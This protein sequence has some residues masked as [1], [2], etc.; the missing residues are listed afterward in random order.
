MFM[1]VLLFAGCDLT[2]RTTGIAL[3]QIKKGWSEEIIYNHKIVYP[4]GIALDGNGDLIVA[5]TG[6]RQIVRVLSTGEVMIF[7]DLSDI[8]PVEGIAWQPGLKR[9]LIGTWYGSL[10]AYSEGRLTLLKPFG[11]NARTLAVDP[12]D[13]SFYCGSAAS[14]G[15]IIHYDADGNVIE[16]IVRN[17]HGCFQIALDEENNRLV[18][19]E[20]FDGE[21]VELNLTDKTT[22]VIA[23]GLGIPGTSE[24]IAVALD[25]NNQ[26]YYFTVVQGLYRHNGTSFEFVMDS[27]SGI[28][29]LV[30]SSQLGSFAVAN[31]VGANIIAYDPA[32]AEA[33]FITPY[34][35]S[36]NIVEMEDGTV[37]VSAENEIMRVTP[38]GFTAFAVQLD[39]NCTAL[40]RDG[41]GTIYAGFPAGII[42]TLS[43]AGV[44]TGWAEGFGYRT[45]MGIHYDVKNDELVVISG[46]GGGTTADVWRVPVDAPDKITHVTTLSGVVVH[47]TLPAGTVD[48]SGNIY[49]LERTANVIYKI[50]DG[51]TNPAVFLESVLPSEAVSV[52]S[53]EYLSKENAVVV[54]TITSYDL[55]SLDHPFKLTLAV[56][57]GAVDNFAMHETK[58]GNLV[59]IHSGQVFRLVHDS[60]L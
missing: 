32:A 10:Y 20:T 21:V 26:L 39:E 50:A 35:N 54:S 1:P 43:S 40:E 48:K 19:S 6:K 3:T 33:V 38:E 8:A 56:N 5:D 46:D 53:L 37:L 2:G 57:N 34:I 45:V 11:I 14:S 59:C 24:P 18:Y 9:L 49:I 60:N 7:A 55:W 27:V 51:S 29:Q 23:S 16:T 31:G 42:Y 13:D 17:V 25:A 47:D 28:G 36:F 41:S 4:A 30:W 12:S 52:P 15:S 58:S 22:S 44:L